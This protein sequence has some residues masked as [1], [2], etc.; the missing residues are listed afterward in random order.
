MFKDVRTPV[1][2]VVEIKMN[3]YLRNSDYVLVNLPL[4]D[5][6]GLLQRLYRHVY[7]GL[8]DRH[9]RGLVLRITHKVIPKI[10]K[11]S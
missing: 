6:K 2:Y 11:M 5:N 1:L 4:P 3:V 9:G 10:H 7:K 8:L